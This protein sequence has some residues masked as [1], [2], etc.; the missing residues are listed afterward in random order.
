MRGCSLL[1]KNSLTLQKVMTV[2]LLLALITLMLYWPVQ[3][4]E[5]IN[6][7]DDI[8]VTGNRHVQSGLSVE[9]LTWSVGTF[10]CGNWH[11][12]TWFS[13]MADVEVYGLHAGGHHW[14]SV[15]IHTTSAVLLFLVLTG[16]THSIGASALVAVLFALHPLHVESV[17]WVSE[18]K[19][20]LSG[21]FWILAMGTYTHYV[22]HPTLSRYL[23]VLGSF[24]LGLLSKPMAVT[25]PFVFLLLDYWPLGRF[26]GAYTA[27]DK[28]VKNGSTPGR[29]VISR[30]AV[31]KIPLLTM[32]AA[33][34]IVTVCAQ[35]SIHSVA[36]LGHNPMEERL[37]N[38]AAAYARYIQ[39]MLWPLDLSVFYPHT[40]M[41][42]AWMTVT[43]L[44]LIIIMSCIAIRK[45][46]AMPFLVVGWFWYLG[47]LVPVIGLVQV[48]SQS[49]ADRYTYIPLVG[50]FI[51]IA[52]GAKHLIA[53]QPGLKHAAATFSF[54]I[55]LGLLLL[56]RSQVETWKNSITVFEHALAVTERNALAHNNVGA[57]Y[58]AKDRS[59]V[60]ALPHFMRALELKTDYADVYDNLGTC[61]YR[62]GKHEEAMRHFQKAL[63]INPQ[64][65]RARVNLGLAMMECGMLRAAENEFNQVLKIDASMEIAHVNLSA[66]SIQ[67]GRLADAAMSLSEALR[68]N[69]K[70]AEAHNNMGVIFLRT[71]RTED[72]LRQF[73]LALIHAPGHPTAEKNIQYI[74]A[75]R[76]R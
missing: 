10:Q 11:P 73:Q 48:G 63:E 2:S 74:I 54:V 36:S 35:Q 68:I 41:P 16:M 26:T 42:P 58:D 62:T 43:S 53:W 47:T 66:I 24:M 72:A 18:R 25:L 19:D 52:W 59:C 37:A 3:S 50:L 7:D 38:A 49:M 39:K 44:L 60:R 67:Q 29:H 57:A 21:L 13:H 31:E 4:F 23:L 6:F 15:L 14:T 27:F 1:K 51:A 65:S 46:R 9:G 32:T 55:L 34:C 17:A 22:R 8:Y 76:S 20:V 70:N 61:A 75:H 5:F 33:S 56:A 45:C 71:G 28:W 69:P 40:G 30:L 64:F 12:L